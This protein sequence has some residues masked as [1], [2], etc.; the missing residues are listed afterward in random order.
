MHASEDRVVCRLVTLAAGA[1]AGKFLRY[2]E[3]APMVAAQ[4]AYGI[5][6]SLSVKIP[7]SFHHIQ[8]SLLIPPRADQMSDSERQCQCPASHPAF[9]ETL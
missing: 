1:A 4:T 5:E 9:A 6:V 7:F 3:N 8:D 2:E